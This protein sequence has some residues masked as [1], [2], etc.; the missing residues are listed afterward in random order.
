MRMLSAHIN[1]VTIYTKRAEGREAEEEARITV[2]VRF[3][4]TDA[5]IYLFVLRQHFNS[6]VLTK[7]YTNEFLEG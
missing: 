2:V 6:K 3:C 7:L 5:G 1:A 4:K